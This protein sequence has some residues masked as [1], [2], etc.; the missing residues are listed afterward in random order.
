M[1][2]L[3]ARGE[4][5][6]NTFSLPQVA[7][8]LAFFYHPSPIVAQHFPTTLHQFLLPR[9]HLPARYY[10]SRHMLL[11]LLTL[12]PFHSPLIA[13]TLPLSPVHVCRSSPSCCQITHH[14]C[15]CPLPLAG[16][17]K[18]SKWVHGGRAPLGRLSPTA[19]T[20][21]C[22][23]PSS[24]PSRYAASSSCCFA[25]PATAAGACRCR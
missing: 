18:G 19:G 22:Q 24:V 8:V 17:G 3:L 20:S 7:A 10:L 25:R 23:L 11:I 4:R 21:S 1:I 13:A 9:A 5:R 16:A 14:A 12:A 2:F 6:G 15:I